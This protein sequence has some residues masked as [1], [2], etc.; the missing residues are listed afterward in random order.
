VII[1]RPEC[2]PVL[3]VETDRLTE[4]VVVPQFSCLIVEIFA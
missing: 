2:A 4:D 3:L 1:H